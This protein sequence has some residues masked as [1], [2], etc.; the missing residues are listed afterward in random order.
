MPHPGFAGAG[1]STEAYGAHAACTWLERCG[2]LGGVYEI[3][4][5]ARFS[6]LEGGGGLEFLRG[7][8]AWVSRWLRHSGGSARSR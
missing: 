5:I 1:A 4:D 7:T 3:D 2:A 6:V 8:G